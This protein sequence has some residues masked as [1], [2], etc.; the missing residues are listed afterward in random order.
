MTPEERKARINHHLYDKPKI[1]TENAELIVALEE[2]VIDWRDFAVGGADSISDWN[3]RQADLE[4]R[5]RE[6]GVEV[7]S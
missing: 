5:M 3:H 1:P 2:L 7:D 4:Q 6:L